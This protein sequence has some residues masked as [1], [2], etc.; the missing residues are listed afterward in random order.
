MHALPPDAFWAA[1]EARYGH[2][3]AL[4]RRLAASTGLAGWLAWGAPRVQASC[5]R[6]P[7]EP[8][9]VVLAAARLWLHPASAGSPERAA[10]AAAGA[11]GR[12]PRH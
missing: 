7:P 9:A 11:P 6:Q 8:V 2:N 5:F 1:M 4:V 3:P 12:L 10:H